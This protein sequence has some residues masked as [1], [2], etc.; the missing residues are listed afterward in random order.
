MISIPQK[1]TRLLK[2]KA[3][4][5]GF[6]FCGISNA[7]FLEEEAPRLESWLDRQMH[8]KMGYM[9]NHFD[10]RLD[11][12]LLVDGA[13]SVVTVL[14]NYYPEKTIACEEDGYKISKYAYGT[15]YHFVIKNKLKELLAFVHEE[16]GE[17]GGRFFVDSAPVMDKVWAKRSGLGWV[18]K[19]TNL[20][21]REMGSFV[22]IGELILDLELIPDGPIADYCGTCTRCI[23]A[24]PTDAI[25]DPYVVDGSKCISYFTIELKEAIPDEVK[26]KFE[27]W[28]FGC[29]I[30]QDVCPW[31]RFSR[32]HHTPDFDPNP[33]LT[34]FT[35]ND[36]EEITQE[37]FQEIFRRSAVKR[38]KL[39]GLKR[40][41]AFVKLNEE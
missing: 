14:L 41:V 10:K 6:D 36:W 27:N 3:A 16:I 9:A 31:N 8:G 5:L 40:N 12:R 21:T 23:D 11:P 26:G 4:E 39:E 18:G 32:P 28:I 15:D 24:C 19:H 33:A 20:I 34:E 38:T 13:R 2:S 7:E 1:H 35:K 37:I 17:V 29:D 22:F 25:T 30:C